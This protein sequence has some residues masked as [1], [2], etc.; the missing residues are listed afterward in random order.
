M[1][2]AEVSGAERSVRNGSVDQRV[3]GKLFDAPNAQATERGQ[4]ANKESDSGLIRTALVGR[5]EVWK[6]M[7]LSYAAAFQRNRT[8][9]RPVNASDLWN[10]AHIA[11]INPNASGSIG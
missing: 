7:K 10:G 4:N 3:R 9:G 8:S 5:A 2:Q 11:S 1:V 6:M